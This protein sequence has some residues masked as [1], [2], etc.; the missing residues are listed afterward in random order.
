MFCSG[1]RR[2]RSTN[3]C[4]RRSRAIPSDS[5][6]AELWNF[7]AGKSPWAAASLAGDA[8]AIDHAGWTVYDLDLSESPRQIGIVDRDMMLVVGCGLFLLTVLL[9]FAKGD[10]SW[11]HQAIALTVAT[12]LALLLPASCA[13]LGA[14]LWLG[15]AAGWTL[16]WL[17]PWDRPL[18][19]YSLRLLV[20]AA[21]PMNGPADESGEPTMLSGSLEPSATAARGDS[22]S[23]RDSAAPRGSGSSPVSDITP[24]S[25]RSPSSGTSSVRKRGGPAG[26]TLGLLLLLGCLVWHDA[27]AAEPAG[28][29]AESSNIQ[30]AS[31]PAEPA[32]PQASS[33]DVQV[34]RADSKRVDSQRRPT[35]S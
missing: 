32:K 20:A 13:P 5:C 25:V 11:K 33:S 4:S 21:S 34:G 23:H 7:P 30:T 15:L 31:A 35:A 2:V 19:A 16:R 12:A 8:P 22:K 28:S 18:G 29:V 3:R 27:G 6:A 10:V 24:N 26:P 1:R 14:G 17:A 9:V